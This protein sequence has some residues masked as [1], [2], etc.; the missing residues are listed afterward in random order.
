[1]DFGAAEPKT[2]GEMPRG[3][4]AAR[5]SVAKCSVHIQRRR[6]SRA[7][8]LYRGASPSND[9]TELSTAVMPEGFAMT[10]R[11]HDAKNSP[12]DLDKEVLKLIKVTADVRRRNV[13]VIDTS[14][15]ARF[16]PV[17]AGRITRSWCKSIGRWTPR[18]AA[19]PARGLG[20]DFAATVL[21]QRRSRRCPSALA[22]ARS[23][24]GAGLEPRACCRAP[25]LA[26]PTQTARS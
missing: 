5:P 19:S 11:Q 4:E 2:N 26:P 25:T 22:S 6:R 24:D 15:S 7:A 18:W 9:G 23:D 20:C 17:T 10:S 12:L 13:T 14:G 8:K 3:E 1:M 21:P 16:P